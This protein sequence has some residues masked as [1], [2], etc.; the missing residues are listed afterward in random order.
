MATVYTNSF[1]LSSYYSQ[2]NF[3]KAST[4]NNGDWTYIIGLRWPST[5]S[6]GYLIQKKDAYQMY[7][8]GQLNLDFQISRSGGA[9]WYRCGSLAALNT[10]G[11]A[12]FSLQRSTPTFSCYV[13]T[14]GSSLSSKSAPDIVGGS[15]TISDDSAY[16]LCLG[17]SG[18]PSV[19]PTEVFFFG[20]WN[21][22]LTLSTINNY[23]SDMDANGKSS[24]VLYIKP[25]FGDTTAVDLS[26]NGNNGTL[27]TVTVGDGPN[28]IRA[29]IRSKGLVNVRNNFTIQST[30][31][32]SRV[33]GRPI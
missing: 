32:R 24:S 22:V 30:G 1:N 21:S 5:T 14:F 26:G 18:V 33:I 10:W 28:P 20:R 6:D 29:K 7:G 12:A 2:I 11:W 23:V 27:S 3:G 17:S 19:R 4:L 13:G 9:S 8:Q 25:T 16:D 15:G 31:T